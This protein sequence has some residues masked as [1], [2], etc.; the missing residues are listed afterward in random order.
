MALKN[1]INLGNI[2][3]M[4]LQ[5]VREIASLHQNMATKYKEFANQCQDQKLKQMFQ[6]SAQDAE[7]TASS[8]TNSLK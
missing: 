5:H 4:E 1:T 7:T 6:Q 8:L 3:Q 2:N